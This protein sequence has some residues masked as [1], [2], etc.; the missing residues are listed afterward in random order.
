M[1]AQPVA[2]E[3]RRQGQGGVLKRGELREDAGLVGRRRG[4][5]EHR[6]RQGASRYRLAARARGGHGEQGHQRTDHRQRNAVELYL[7]GAP[8][9]KRPGEHGPRE[10]PAQHERQRRERDGRHGHRRGNHGLDAHQPPHEIIGNEQVHRQREL[11]ARESEGSQRDNR[12]DEPVGS[13]ESLVLS[14]ELIHEHHG[15]RPAPATPYSAQGSC[16]LVN[17]RRALPDREARGRA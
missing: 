5:Q 9:Q 8:R 7:Q 16:E 6:R 3:R 2:G 11:E 15:K 14:K 12:V 4:E 10:L 17:R 13:R 1:L